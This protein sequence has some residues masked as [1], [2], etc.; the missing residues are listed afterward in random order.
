MVL[1]MGKIEQSDCEATCSQSLDP[2]GDIPRLLPQ[3]SQAEL[4]HFDEKSVLLIRECQEQ[5]QFL[6]H[7]AN[8]FFQL[9]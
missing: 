8:H 3:K 4:G 7:Q 5:E 1:V 9:N 6:S 2:G